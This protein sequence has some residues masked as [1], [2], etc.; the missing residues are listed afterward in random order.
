MTSL[1]LTSLS[2]NSGVAILTLPRRS[3]ATVLLQEF[4]S[5]LRAVEE[6]IGK[7]G[8]SLREIQDTKKSRTK[9]K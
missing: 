7:L 2:Q 4:H 5:K 6:L 1:K 9:T 3:A 8:F